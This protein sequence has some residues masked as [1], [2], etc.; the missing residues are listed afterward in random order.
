MES[1]VAM[2]LHSNQQPLSQ[3]RTAI[4]A[5][6]E[7][8]S[9]IRAILDHFG[10]EVDSLANSTPVSPGSVTQSIVLCLTGRF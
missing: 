1:L 7:E 9:N 2:R 6:L 5:V 8:W 3:E 10:K 4:S